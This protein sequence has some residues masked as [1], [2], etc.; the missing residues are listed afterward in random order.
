MFHLVLKLQPKIHQS[1]LVNHQATSQYI[2]GDRNT[3]CVEK[4]V[5]QRFQVTGYSFHVDSKPENSEPIQGFCTFNFI[6]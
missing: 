5:Q 6:S 3:I 4:E 2:K 1:I